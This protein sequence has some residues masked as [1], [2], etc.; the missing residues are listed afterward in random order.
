M[1]RHRGFEMSVFAAM[2]G[3]GAARSSNASFAVE[4]LK[5][6]ALPALER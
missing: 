3:R 2:D 4:L 1:S 6:L 5:A